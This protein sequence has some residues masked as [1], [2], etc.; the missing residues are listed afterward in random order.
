MSDNKPKKIR[1]A[2]IL[3]LIVYIGTY[4]LPVSESFIGNIN[5]FLGACMIFLD[6]KE[7]DLYPSN[8]LTQ[9]KILHYIILISH[10]LVSARKH[11]FFENSFISI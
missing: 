1:I 10:Y 3:V 7:F 11:P 2:L 4:F 8:W 9:F 5:G 6:Y